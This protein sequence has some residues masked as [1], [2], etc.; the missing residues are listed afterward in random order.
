MNRPLDNLSV[1]ADLDREFAPGICNI[2]PRSFTLLTDD[3]MRDHTSKVAFKDAV[4]GYGVIDL[5][6]NEF[7]QTEKAVKIRY[8]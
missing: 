2:A 3:R 1:T 8:A 4:N 7:L 5:P 6:V